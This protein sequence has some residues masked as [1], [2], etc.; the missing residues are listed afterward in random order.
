MKKII[1]YLRKI[2][3]NFDNNIFTSGGNVNLNCILGYK[4]DKESFS[5]LDNYDK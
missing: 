5:F 4:K 2:N 3:K 1:S